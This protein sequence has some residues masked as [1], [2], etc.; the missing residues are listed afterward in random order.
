MKKTEKNEPQML[1]QQKEQNRKDGLK[2]LAWF[3]KIYYVVMFAGLSYGFIGSG[4]VLKG[5]LIG[6]I[7]LAIA[8]LYLVLKYR[9]KKQKEDNAT[10]AAFTATSYIAG[11][12][13]AV[14]EIQT[15]SAER[16]ET[17]A[18]RPEEEA[19]R[20][21]LEKEHKSFADREHGLDDIF[22]E[23][24]MNHLD[25]FDMP[26]FVLSRPAT[27]GDMSPDKYV[28]D[29]SIYISLKD[30]VIDQQF[31]KDAENC[32]GQSGLLYYQ[33][34]MHV[35]LEDMLAGKAERIILYGALNVPIRISRAEA[36]KIRD[37]IEIFEIM[38]SSVR[39][40]RYTNEEAYEKL[41]AYEFFFIGTLPDTVSGDGGDVRIPKGES[42]SLSEIDR[43][44]NGQS[45]KALRLFVST[46]SADK[47]G[48]KGY[49]LV[50]WPL[51]KIKNFYGGK[52]IIEPHRS[53]WME[54]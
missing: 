4:E 25:T 18:L 46:Q 49:N 2:Y 52:V 22:T 14:T 7:A 42:F 13:T 19:L 12:S 5:C 38:Y 16:K 24:R 21:L 40:N 54:F 51:E 34:P 23:S 1:M 11:N 26:F 37:E 36:E 29:G 53:W 28:F 35:F 32:F 6:G 10:T 44:E 8:I 15:R 20:T 27:E 45:Y 39:G 33:I 43:E 50:K 41:K 9:K 48:G 31:I 17:K 30:G 47:F 3:G